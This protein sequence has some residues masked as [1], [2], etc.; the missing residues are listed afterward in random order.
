MSKFPQKHLP[1]RAKCKTSK[2][3]LRGSYLAGHLLARIDNPPRIGND[4]EVASEKKKKW[5]RNHPCFGSG[6]A[7]PSAISQWNF[8]ICSC[9]LIAL[10]VGPTALCLVPLLSLTDPAVQIVEPPFFL[11]RCTSFIPT[12]ISFVL[13]LPGTFS[14]CIIPTSS[15]SLQSL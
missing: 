12:L 15:P 1:K 13:L 7:I 10:S 11:G 8:A 3:V 6:F 4:T 9:C 5:R 14:P 2:S